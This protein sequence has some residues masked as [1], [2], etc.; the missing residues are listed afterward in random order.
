MLGLGL[1]ERSGR[2][3]LRHHFSRPKT[4]SSDI[5]NR[6]LRGALLLVIRIENGGAV[7]RTDIIALPVAR[8]GIVNLKEDFQQFTIADFR[9]IKE[10]LDPLGMLAVIAIGGVWDLAPGIADTGRDNAGI[11]P[12]QVLHSPEAAAGQNRTFIRATHFSYSFEGPTIR[13]I[14]P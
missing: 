14:Q 13:D 8:R 5:G 10:N 4:R 11:A 2:N 6:L 3:N 1:P 7:T 12:Q 9:R